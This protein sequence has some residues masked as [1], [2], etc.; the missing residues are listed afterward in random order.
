[1]VLMGIPGRLLLTCVVAGGIS[2]LPL[3]PPASA[4]EGIE[5]PAAIAFLNQQ[6][7]ANGIPPVTENQEFASA[8]CPDEDNGPS[9]GELGRDLSPDVSGWSA[10]SSPWDNAPLHQ[11][12]MYNPLYTKVGDVDR[13]GQACLGAGAPLPEPA[14]PT[15]ATFFSGTGP[16]NVPTT[17]TIYG[18][19]PFAPQQL[20]GLPLG[21]ATGGQLILYAEGMGQE[22]HAL[23]WTLTGADGTPV[24]DVKLVDNTDANA[25]GYMGYLMGV[26]ILIPP[27]LE[28][29]STYN[30]TV[31]WEGAG[32]TTATQALSFKTGGA[33]N[34]LNIYGKGN[35][36]YGESQAPGG[37]FTV[38]RGSRSLQ[39]AIST[40]TRSRHYRGRLAIS[41]LSPGRW[42]LCVASG[43]GTTAYLY[44][45]QCA[46]L[47]LQ[48]D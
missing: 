33:P 23:S 7:A 48:R 32:G 13:G 46:Y 44:Q 15:F 11:Q 38:S 36:L 28:A 24:P 35:Y 45:R 42:R 37:V 40:Q 5:G 8:W 10:S 1:M 9:G 2:L 14:A 20:V 25:A 41:R 39:V 4:A 43:G 47:S 26:G 34:Q 6:R 30:L 17:E 18:E 27:P 3:G 12:D 16:E 22:V 29:H 31:I 19:G 21:E